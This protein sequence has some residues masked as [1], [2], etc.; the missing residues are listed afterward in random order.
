[1]PSTRRKRKQFK[2]FQRLTEAQ[3][4]LGWGVILILAALLGSIYLS[5][6]SRIAAV[7]RR[8]QDLQERLDDLKRENGVLE[9]QIAEAQS[10]E[11]LQQEAVRLGFVQAGPN[12]IEYI[13][14][15][16]YPAEET[17]VPVPITSDVP[18]PDIL[19]P[20]VLPPD[21]MSE[22]L[23]LAL[24]NSVSSLIYGEAGE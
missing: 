22:V 18:S 7:G 2:Q 20:A 13:I 9:R 21:T 17:A 14:V 3:A 24:Q 15:P 5:Q 11:R 23:W 8:V 16:D 19:S 4:A 12:D 1:M 6:T 10:L